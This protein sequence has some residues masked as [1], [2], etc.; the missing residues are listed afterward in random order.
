MRRS[1]R[2]GILQRA[3]KSG[4]AAR[5]RSACRPSRRTR[6]AALDLLDRGGEDDVGHD[7]DASPRVSR[8]RAAA[9][10]CGRAPGTGRRGRAASRPPRS[11]RAAAGR[12]PAS[13]S[14][15]T[16]WWISSQPSVDAD[17]RR[18]GADLQGLA[19]VLAHGDELVVAQVDQ[20]ADVRLDLRR[21]GRRRSRCPGRSSVDPGREERPLARATTSRGP[22]SAGAAS[23]KDSPRPGPEPARGRTPVLV[24]EQVEVGVEVRLVA[25]MHRTEPPPATPGRRRRPGRPRPERPVGDVGHDVHGRALGPR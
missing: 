11:A 18:A 14:P 17:R 21:P 4:P 23:A 20:V 1:G 15:V 6:T 9:R 13:S 2:T 8:A 3:P 19:L 22:T 12:R 16:P 25:E 24:R 10:W 7:A 5:P